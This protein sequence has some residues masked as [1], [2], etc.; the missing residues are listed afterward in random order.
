MNKKIVLQNSITLLGKRGLKYLCF[1]ILAAIGIA[2]VELS[3]SIIIQLLLGSFNF[4]STPNKIFNYEIPKISLNKV[5]IL[6]LVVA[7][8]RFAVQLTTTQTAAFLKDYILLKLKRNYVYRILF[9]ENIKDKNP[10]TINFTLA[11]VF[12]KS[13]EFVLNFT[14]FIFMF[15][16]SL[17]IFFLLFLV[18]WKEAIVAT[19]GISIIGITIIYINKKVSLFAKQVPN[20]QKIVN[21][22][23]E[24][25]ARNFLFIKLMRKREDEFNVTS[26]ALKNYSTKSVS[27]NFFSNLSAQ[28]GPFLGIFL[29]VFIIIISYSVWHTN[30]VVLLSFIYLLARFVQSLSILSG[31]FGNAVIYYPQYKLSLD[32]IN[33]ED[34]FHISKENNS[35]ISFFGPIKNTKSSE[36]QKQNSITV[37]DKID[38]PDITIKEVTFSYPNSNPLFKNLNL[39]ISKG[40][41]IGLIG[42]SGTGKSTILM[43]MT[44]ILKP[45]EGEVIIGGLPAWEYISRNETRIG[46]VGPEPFLIKGTLKENLSYGLSRKVSDNE[47][48]EALQLVSLSDILNEKGLDYMLD[49]NFA[50]LSAGQKQRIC[51][52]RSILNKPSLMI[53]DEATANLDETN[54]LLI[55]KVLSNI[56]NS[57][58]TIIVSHRYGIL[59]YADEIID[60]KNIIK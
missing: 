23:I 2:V 38:S 40:A 51:L 43:L 11:E 55:A 29:L 19:T 56:K 35:K 10:S 41:Q 16:Q 52:A 28:T 49:E 21:E 22:G 17:F 24:K 20:E 7:I 36:N 1:A 33:S 37:S 5:T 9:D 42:S 6:L 59:T 4:I 48:I 60:I 57:C 25:I 47:I 26:N 27:A 13:S 45:N 30:S 53:L 58:T 14:H 8:V 12:T 15:M 39:N 18:A 44:G 31:Y 3:I 50:G 32:S 34:F 46:Y 54:E